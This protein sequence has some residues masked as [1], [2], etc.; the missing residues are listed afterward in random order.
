MEPSMLLTM[1]SNTT[2]VVAVGALDVY[3]DTEY[4]TLLFFGK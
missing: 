2:H 3:N 1:A 4:S